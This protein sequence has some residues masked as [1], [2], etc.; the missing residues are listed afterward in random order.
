MGRSLFVSVFFP[1]IWVIVLPLSG[2]MLSKFESMEGVGLSLLI[3]VSSGLVVVLM[4][5]VSGA[6]SSGL[7][8]V[9]VSA[10]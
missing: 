6:I 10:V 3:V 5:F 7:I 1:G 4:F 9:M 8:G 2:E